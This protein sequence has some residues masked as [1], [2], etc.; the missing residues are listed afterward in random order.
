MPMPEHV[1][2]GGGREDFCFLG[3]CRLLFKLSI[4]YPIRASATSKFLP[5]KSYKFVTEVKEKE[6]GILRKRCKEAVDPEEKDKIR[7][8][9]KRT[10]NQLRSERQKDEKERTDVAAVADIKTKLERGEKHLFQSKKARREEGLVQTYRQLQEKGG[11]DTYIK[12]R[13]KANVAKDRK[14]M[15]KLY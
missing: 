4:F 12:K 9:I 14:L 5:R 11:L 7:F 6:L 8:L 10:E 2:Y 15:D 13:S 1:N 3:N